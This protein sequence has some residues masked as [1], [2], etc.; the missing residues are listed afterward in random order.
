MLKFADLPE[1]GQTKLY[2]GR[3]GEKFDRDITVGIIYMLKLYHMVDDKI[4]ADQPDHIVWLLNNHLVVKLNLEGKGLV[5]WK[6]GHSK[7]ME[8]LIHYKKF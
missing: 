2:D 3:T 7:L 1:S 4:H 8:Q 5:K 6:F